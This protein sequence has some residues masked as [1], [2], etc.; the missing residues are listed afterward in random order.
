MVGEFHVVSVNFIM[1]HYMQNSIFGETSSLL[2]NDKINIMQTADK[3]A[4]EK[5]KQRIEK[6]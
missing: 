3:L 2:A 1:S 5:L 6:G 4:T